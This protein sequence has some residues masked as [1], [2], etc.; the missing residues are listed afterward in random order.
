MAN[1]SAQAIALLVEELLAAIS[2]VGPLGVELYLKLQSLLHLGPDEQANVV[3]AIKA[4]LAADAE[5]IAAVEAWKQQ[6]GL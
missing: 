5:T 4:G 3:A 1:L 2:A 6:V